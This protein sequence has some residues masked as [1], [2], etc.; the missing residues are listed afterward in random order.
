MYVRGF[1]GFILF[2]NGQLLIPD[3]LGYF[4]DDFG[5]FENLVKI[6]TCGPPNYYQ[7]ALKNTRN[8]GIILETII[9][10]NMGLQDF[11]LFRKLNVLGTMFFDVCETLNTC[12]ENNFTKMRIK[13]DKLPL[14]KSTKAWI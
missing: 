12:F 7:N 4:L 3:R 9:F 5:N 2:Q 8:Y 14:I 11:E 10:V 1:L 6:W 13:N